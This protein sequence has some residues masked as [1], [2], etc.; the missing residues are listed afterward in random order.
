LI[1]EI[2]NVNIGAIGLASADRVDFFIYFIV[3]WF[4]VFHHVVL[5]PN[6]LIVK[7]TH[8][9]SSIQISNANYYRHAQIHTVDQKYE[10]SCV[11]HLLDYFLE[12]HPALFLVCLFIVDDNLALD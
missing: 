4:L 7:Q 3:H 5:L 10:L 9:I 8:I 1:V 12:I 2:A 11:Q 6:W